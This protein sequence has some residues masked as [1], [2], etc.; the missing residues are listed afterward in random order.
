MEIKNQCQRMLIWM[1]LFCV[2]SDALASKL[3]LLSFSYV[4]PPLTIASVAL[5]QA[6]I[7]SDFFFS[8][9]SLVKVKKPEVN[10]QITNRSQW[11]AKFIDLHYIPVGAVYNTAGEHACNNL[12][13]MKPGGS[14]VIHFDVDK[15]KYRAH[16][17]CGPHVQHQHDDYYFCSFTTAVNVATSTQVSVTPVMQDGLRYDAATHAIVGMPTR[18]GIYEFTVGASNSGVTAS[19]VILRINVNVNSNDT[20]VFK[21]QYGIASAMPNRTYRL[22]LMDLIEKKSSFGVTNQVRFRI[23]PN[24]TLDYPEWIKLDP[25]SG[26]VLEGDVP[27]SD[28]GTIKELSVIASSNTG[29]DSKPFLIRIPVA[30]DATKKPIIQHD[31]DFKGEVASAFHQNV[32]PF[33]VDPAEDGRLNVILDKVEP[34]APW[35]SMS[36]AN[37]LMGVVPSDAVGHCYRLT[38]RAITP[39]GGSSDPVTALLHIGIDPQLTPRFMEPNAP[40]PFFYAGQ[41]YVFDLT[42]F[43]GIY[44]EYRDFPYKVEIADGHP[45]PS[46]LRIEDNKIIVDKVPEDERDLNPQLYVTIQ[47]APGG[48][49]AAIPI[50]LYIMR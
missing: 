12:K 19:P 29:G 36:S 6:Y 18:M 46:W 4:K 35:L 2:V 48:I 28:V 30:Y 45:H 27:V 13:P 37:V 20:P 23:D 40:L 34:A 1:G 24:H 42:T 33:I 50:T 49:S 39:V 8:L 14:C 7:H 32:V 3:Y 21:H 10:L 9:D 26:T 11:D 22:N 17:D 38:L 41:P 15:S 47:N 25:T 43:D 44:P 16:R 5:Q 31:L